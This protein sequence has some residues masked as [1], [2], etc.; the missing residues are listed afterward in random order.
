MFKLIKTG[1][2]L[3]RS[4]ITD[5]SDD[6]LST[7]RDIS[8]L[9]NE[10][11][12]LRNN[13]QKLIETDVQDILSFFDSLA[14]KWMNNENDFFT[15][16]GQ[17]GISFLLS[18]IRS[19]NL[20]SIVLQSLNGSLDMLNGF[21]NS[22]YLGKKLLASPKGVVVHWLAGNVP[23]LGMISLI[24]GILTKNIN[25]IKL[26]RSNGYVLPA[27]ISEIEMHSV[28][29]KSGVLTGKDI[30]STILFCY[31]DRS[32]K[33]AQSQLSDIAD[34]RVAWGGKE[35]VES[36]MT[37]NKRYFTEDIIFGPKYSFAVI[38]KDSFSKDDLDSLA[39]KMAMDASVFE[40]QGC[41]SPHTLFFE[42]GGHVSAEE[43][44]QS[45]AKAMDKV[46]K[47][48]PK[49]P[50]SG[51]EAIDITN[52]R[53]E[54]IFDGKKVFKSS[55]VEWTIVLTDDK[56]FSDA[57][58]NRTLFINRVNHLDDVL[59]SVDYYHQTMGLC[60]KKDKKDDFILK[61]SR[62]GIERVT[63]IGKMSVYDHPWDGLFPL[64]RFVRWTSVF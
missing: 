1:A 14:V 37:L 5:L 31:C 15:R 42:E 9:D 28:N 54:A 56:E 6:F 48:I 45:V 18:F 50:L 26:P 8:S 64:S 41:N 44:S 16:F 43:F 32:D 49:Q 51:K 34:V 17:Y 62:K 57:C 21:S 58:Y 3:S 27:M 52:L 40:Q 60:I 23:V 12:P 29:T 35:A 2:E 61:A 13:Q 63:E 4:N 53:T 47:R 30:L 33:L 24:Q 59:D 25:I 7:C 22:E 10:V 46:L 39:Y 11:S 20:E 19:S 36:V 38:G 55:G